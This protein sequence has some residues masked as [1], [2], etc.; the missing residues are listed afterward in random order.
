MDANCHTYVRTASSLAVGHQGVTSICERLG[1]PCHN[2]LYQRF[3]QGKLSVAAY[4]GDEAVVASL[5]A[6][7]AD[8]NAENETLGPPLHAAVL[9][10]NVPIVSLF[11][12]NKADPNV[13]GS[14]GTL[15]HRLVWYKNEGLLRLLLQQNG[16]R[17]NVPDSKGITPLWWS[18]FV[19]EPDTVRLI[20]Q[21]K[22]TDPNLK[23]R[24]QSPLSAA[25]GQGHETIVRCLM[26]QEGVTINLDSG[27]DCSL[28]CT[29]FNGQ[30]HVLQLIWDKL[31]V[32][33]DEYGLCSKSL[34]WW[35]AHDGHA[36]V[37]QI[38]LKRND[39]NP[40]FDGGNGD[41]PL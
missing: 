4:R 8:V 9:N 18:C 24:G 29:A 38:L 11:L 2:Q 5:I 7:G 14:W 31:H 1:E 13:C 15:L 10:G 20:L 21:H 22:D 32:S 23:C 25:A 33:L 26:E 34:L 3:L 17:P 16:L 37:V 41:T 35:A 12:R 40:N 28:W 39:V 27:M 19:G 36:S 6:Q 30:S